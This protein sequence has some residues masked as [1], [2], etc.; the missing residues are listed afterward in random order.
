MAANTLL[1]T[2]RDG[3]ELSGYTPIL[4]STTIQQLCGWLEKHVLSGDYKPYNVFFSGP[5]KDNY[6]I[7][8]LSAAFKDMTNY[9]YSTT[10]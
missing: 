8:N 7:S 5:M 4:V 1:Y 2:W 9:K 6:L 3:T 10:T